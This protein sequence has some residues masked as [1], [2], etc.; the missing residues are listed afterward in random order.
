MSAGLLPV[1]TVGA[2]STSTT[3]PGPAGRELKPWRNRSP[4]LRPMATTPTS[5]R[6]GQRPVAGSW[7][8][9]LDSG[10][11]DWGLKYC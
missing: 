3:P 8:D 10:I 5:W 1:P 2:E 4:S 7:A 9:F 6:K 11:S